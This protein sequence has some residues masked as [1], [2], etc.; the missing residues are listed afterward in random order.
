MRIKKEVK[1]VH[2]KL[3][4]LNSANTYRSKV[5]GISTFNPK[6]LIRSKTERPRTINLNKS[7]NSVDPESTWKK[8]S[9]DST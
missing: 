1:G 8:K 5:K 6:K 7:K 2:G 3:L 4:E 9:L